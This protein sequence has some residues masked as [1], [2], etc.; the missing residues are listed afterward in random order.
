MITREVSM[1]LRGIGTLLVILAHYS[2][3]YITVESGNVIWYLMTKLGRYGVA[4]FF[5]V[6]GYGLVFSAKKGLEARWIIRRVMHVYFPYFCIEGILHLVEG[7]RWTLYSFVKYIV[8]LD[9]WFVFVIVMFYIL[10]WFVWKFSVHKT[11]WMSIGV[12]A[13]SFS[14]AVGMR[15]SVWYASNTAF[16]VG[17]VAGQYDR[18][19]SAW[20]SNKKGRIS[21]VLL[22]AFLCSGGI[23]SF[24]QDRSTGIYLLGKSVASALWAMF[25]VSFFSGREVE[26]RK[27]SILGTASLEIYLIHVFVLDRVDILL[28]RVNAV[29]VLGIGILLSFALGVLIHWMFEVINRKI[30]L[31]DRS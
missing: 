2:Q 26:S 10:F 4:V 14:L 3:W 1:F 19:I 15:D 27:V 11:L 12:A 28:D 22:M 17:V 18:E 7:K 13:V 8:G 20:L 31:L 21:L 9:A 23:Y 29:T 6:S 5:L 16:L 30:S 25:L 24:Y